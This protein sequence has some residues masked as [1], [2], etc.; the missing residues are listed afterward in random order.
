VFVNIP[1]LLPF[2]GR[3]HFPS[4][5]PAPHYFPTEAILCWHW[6][7]CLLCRLKAA[8]EHPE[9]KYYPEE[10]ADL[11][12]EC[13]VDNTDCPHAGRWDIGDDESYP[14]TP[15]ATFASLLKCGCTHRSSDSNHRSIDDTSDSSLNTPVDGPNMPM[16][17]ST[18]LR[19]DYT[20]DSSSNTFVDGPNVPKRD[21]TILRIG[22]MAP[23]QEGVSKVDIHAWVAGTVGADD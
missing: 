1:Y 22:D 4:G 7:Q 5:A 9:D 11:R 2:H 13:G 12:A 17:G 19:V 3:L 6:Q 16:R 23:Q 20:S 21:S 14:P 15:G 8:A 10:N 18:I